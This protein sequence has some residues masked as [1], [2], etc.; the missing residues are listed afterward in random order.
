ML[1]EEPCGDSGLRVNNEFHAEFG[2]IDDLQRRRLL[3]GLM[4]CLGVR[5]FGFLEEVGFQRR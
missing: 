1:K 5:L 3:L 2:E 4:P